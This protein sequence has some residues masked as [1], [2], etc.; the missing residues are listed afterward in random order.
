MA[1][2]VAQC[3]GWASWGRG[4]ERSV[5]SSRKDFSQ[6]KIS[7]TALYQFRRDF[8]LIECRHARID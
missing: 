1:E 4:E 3:E 7:L 5:L 6:N 2:R 8:T